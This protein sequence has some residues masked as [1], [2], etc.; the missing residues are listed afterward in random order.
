MFLRISVNDWNDK[1]DKTFQNP[2]GSEPVGKLMLRFSIP[3]IIAMLV[4]ALYNIVDQLFIGQKVGMLGNAATNVAFPLSTSCIALA[5]LFGIGGA[6]AFNL[7]LGQGKKD[8]A[9]YF[10]GNAVTMLVIS[11]VL[12][13]VI[14]LL[15][16]KPLLRLFGSPEEVMPFAL[17]Y[18][19]I[20]AFGFPF[21]VLTTGGS[22]LVRADGSPMMTMLC[23]ITG[24][25][26][27]TILDAVFVFGFGMGMKGAAIA[28][29]I[30]QVISA[31]M[32]VWY[33]AFR[34]KTVKLNK[35]HLIP[36]AKCC[37]KIFAIGMASFFNQIAM[38]IVQIV[39]NN[40]LRTYGAQSVYGESIPL[41]CAG[42]VMKI[43]QLVFSIVIGLSQG[44]QPIES[45]N[46][47]AQKYDRVKKA[48]F[49]AST[50]AVG[51]S[52]VCFICFQLFPKQILSVFGDG[53]DE[54]FEFGT[55]FLK[56][57]LFFS[58]IVALQPVTSTF[59]TSI[60]KAIKGVFLSLTRQIIFFL[61][62]LLIL[63]RIWGIDGIVYAGPIGDLISSIIAIVMC[64]FEF[65]NMRELEN[66]M[67]KE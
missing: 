17:D 57:F 39:L 59:F 10:M 9:P 31:L 16:L 24:A 8:K 33:L 53:T 11:G 14:T 21:L 41:S 48:Y 3:S 54:Y 52:F 35:K 47:G 64:F 60:G 61:P 4:G 49:L 37:Q 28:T 56:R 45:F 62:A 18:V 58:W 30:G 27:N 6:S 1:M 38:M 42:I 23:S 13:M 2:L 32:I 51:F 12:L 67:T 40:S 20:T 36:S 46:Y 7:T 50:I 19:G 22:H 25:V 5:L 26:I 66:Q 55:R 34:P 44:T 43:S 65:K 29:V 15:F 63:P